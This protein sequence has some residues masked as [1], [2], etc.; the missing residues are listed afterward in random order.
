MPRARI[1]NKFGTMIGWNNVTVNLF[2]RELEGIDSVKYTDKEDHTMVR[3]A[4]KMP[5]GKSKGNYEV[6]AASLSLYIEE[7]IALLKSLPK[8]VR[9]Q[10]IPDFDIPVSYEYQGS[11][12]TDIM[13]NCSFTN[14]GRESKNGEGKI[15][16]EYNL[17]C[18][19][20]DYNV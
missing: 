17:S 15:V 20:I 13:R 4:G 12:Y 9:L 7:N 6:D 2:G 5:I 3:G 16:M 19:H 10:E 18:T 14:N 1:A 8:G 11:V